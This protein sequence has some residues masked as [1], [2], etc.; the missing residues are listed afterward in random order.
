VIVFA[1]VAFVVLV[2]VDVTHKLFLTQGIVD[3]DQ[4]HLIEVQMPPPSYAPV[5]RIVTNMMGQNHL[6][7]LLHLKEKMV[8]YFLSIK[9]IMQPLV[10]VLLH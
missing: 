9:M 4:T 7:T 5:P 3:L 6:L 8:Y 10:H 2:P 1:V